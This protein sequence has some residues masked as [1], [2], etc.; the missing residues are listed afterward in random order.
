L[1]FSPFLA[2]LTKRQ[3][4]ICHHMA[5]LVSVNLLHFSL[6]SWTIW[7]KLGRHSPWMVSILN[8]TI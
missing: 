2:H 8:Y 3:C 4:E 7:T 5:S 6:L 1:N